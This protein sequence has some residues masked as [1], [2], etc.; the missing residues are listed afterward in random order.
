M[1]RETVIYR[2]HEIKSEII[3]QFDNIFG[4]LT[5]HIQD[6]NL[7]KFR[8]AFEKSNQDVDSKDQNEDSL[9]IIAVKSNCY[10]IVD[11]L[12][13][14]HANVNIQDRNFD[15]PLHHALKNKFFKTANLLITKKAD[16]FITNN[17]SLTAW[18][19]LYLDNNTDTSDSCKSFN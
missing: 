3:K 10:E 19:C 4:V 13:Y 12:L 8:E 5:F 17:K 11:Y 7:Q 16:E 1:N 6:K 14:N 2:T 18:Q 9:L 15:T